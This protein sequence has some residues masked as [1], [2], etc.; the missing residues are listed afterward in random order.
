MIEE[1]GFMLVACTQTYE[2]RYEGIDTT[3][4]GKDVKWEGAII[5]KKIHI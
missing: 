3:E 4:K 1:A 2:Q 5:N